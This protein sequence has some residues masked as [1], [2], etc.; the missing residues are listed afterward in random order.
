LSSYSDNPVYRIVR[1]INLDKTKKNI[2]TLYNFRHMFY[3]L[4][5]KTRLRKWLW[6]K[7]REPKIMKYYDPKNLIEKLHET[8]DENADEDE[9]T[10]LDTILNTW[11]N[12]ENCI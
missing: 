10:D 6:E 9:P 5:C 11:I 8:A 1:D 7:V 2:V 12:R 3:S 4:K